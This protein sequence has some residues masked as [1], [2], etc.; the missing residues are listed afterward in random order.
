[1]GLLLSLTFI[2][3]AP[4]LNTDYQQLASLFPI[5]QLPGDLLHIL[6]GTLP[7]LVG[8][9]FPDGRFVPRWTRWLAL[10]VIFF[11]SAGTFF[12]ASPL[13]TD[14]WPD[15]LRT[16]AQLMPVV[17]VVIAQVYRYLRVSSPVQ[18]QQT[19]W[20][21]LGILATIIYLVALSVITALNPDTTQARSLGFLFAE[22]SYI[23]AFLL[24]PLS[25]AFSILRYR[26]W[27]ID[28]LIK[29]TLIY[30]I[31]TGTLALI[32]LGCVILLQNLVNRL[33]SQTGQSPVIIVASTL[34]IAALF[35]PL[36]R[37]IQ[38]LIDRRFYRRKYDAA[39][40]LATFSATLRNEVD[41]TQLREHLLATVQETMQPTHVSLWLRP[42]TPKRK[43]DTD[44][45]H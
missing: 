28:L 2:I 20:V 5:T 16:L 13:N 17:A 9:L 22:A 38:R 18:R 43:R 29:R 42:P 41:L 26:L 45:A 39:R 37:R 10:L 27:D 4:A 15:P 25:I 1:M 7:F 24:V 33:T 36:R 34:L 8:Y 19:K 3:A 32:Y 6:F 40:T 31:L 35:Q 12:P 11:V 23:L 30:S 14:N 21:V 44:D